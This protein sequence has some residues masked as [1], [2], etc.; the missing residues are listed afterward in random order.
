M[1]VWDVE[2]ERCEAT[3]TGHGSDV[4]AV[5]GMKG[6]RLA[7][8]SYDGTVKVWDMRSGQCEATVTGLGGGVSALEE[9]EGGVLA[10]GETWAGYKTKVLTGPPPPPPPPPPRR[11]TRKQEEMLERLKRMWKSE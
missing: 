11:L 5:V 4:M 3:L 7:S 2:N 1:K 8:G 10:V 6:G 9:V